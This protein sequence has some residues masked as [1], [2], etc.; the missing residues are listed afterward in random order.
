MTSDMS[1][2]P[3]GEPGRTGPPGMADWNARAGSRTGL[4]RRVW[5]LPDWF[6]PADFPG[7]R[8]SQVRA[9][10][11]IVVGPLLG[12]SSIFWTLWSAFGLGLAQRPYIAV[13]ALVLVALANGSL[14]LL[15]K[16]GLP[17]SRLSVALITMYFAQSAAI[18]LFTGGQTIE[19][20]QM[21]PMGLAL[22]CFILGLRGGLVTVL[23]TMVLLAGMALLQA[24][25]LVPPSRLP[26]DVQQMVSYYRAAVTALGALLVTISVSRIND[27]M[28]AGYAA[29]QRAAEAG[30]RARSAFLTN[31]SHELRTPIT[32]MLGSI[33]LLEDSRLQQQQRGWLAALRSSTEALSEIL[34]DLLDLSRQQ[35]GERR[36]RP[37]A[38]SPRQLMAEVI[39]LFDA[40]A[41]A[42][43]IWLRG[44]PDPDL[45]AHLALDGAAL[46]QV[47]INLTGNA[48]RATETGGVTL[49]ARCLTGRYG[50]VLTITVRD[51]GHGFA[52]ADNPLPDI[53]PGI[54]GEPAPGQAWRGRATGGLAIAQR[55]TAAIGGRIEA[56]SM[57]GAGA[58]FRVTVPA[59]RLS[60]PPDTVAEAARHAPPPAIAPGGGKSPGHGPA[61]RILVAE[62]SDTNRMLLGALLE[63]IGHRPHLVADGTA[64]L[65]AVRAAEQSIRQDQ[66]SAQDAVVPDLLLL[67]IQMPGLTGT[68]VARAVRL[69]PGPLQAVPI[70]GLTADA[71]PEHRQGY[72][73]AGM[74]ELLYKP[75]R[76]QDL[77]AAIERLMQQSGADRQ[78][79][80]SQGAA[81]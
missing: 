20:L 3:P 63:R 60:A 62:D 48:I 43:G 4:W 22:S 24:G 67:D 28:E 12:V 11:L 77:Q 21:V 15:L 46:R 73:E 16:C 13:I 27:R 8:R 36:D 66:P 75:V 19:F 26:P 74:D 50:T 10:L 42:K 7:D 37:H 76:L 17:L 72:L 23:A 25:G 47:L 41:A 32:G 31:V 44:A 51:T 56:F 69:V 80:T 5:A 65:A 78:D 70:L 45:P 79:V 81:S 33:A 2:R 6:L 49:A 34:T 54:A 18:W 30:N 52:P 35:A 59:E 14:P 58:S 39:T 71:T 68:E 38:V 29:V 64:A 40:Q 9:N 1:Q 61:R 55:L 53:L 57:P